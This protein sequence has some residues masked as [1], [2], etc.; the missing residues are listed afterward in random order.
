MLSL[1]LDR[2]FAMT[3]FQVKD[4][5]SQVGGAQV[6][7][8]DLTNTA[9]SAQKAASVGS[10]QWFNDVHT[11]FLVTC[12]LDWL[13]SF[14]HGFGLSRTMVWRV[15]LLHEFSPKRIEENLRN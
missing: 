9:Q 3:V 15:S 1:K 13:Q 7:A 2:C 11:L 12:G 6:K 8:E 14:P 10:G 4:A 5:V